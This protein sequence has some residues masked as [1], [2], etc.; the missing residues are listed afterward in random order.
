MRVDSEEFARTFGN[1][2]AAADGSDVPVKRSAGGP[3]SFMGD[4]GE[5]GAAAAPAWSICLASVNFGGNTP[6]ARWILLT[7]RLSGLPSE[8]VSAKYSPWTS[9]TSLSTEF[10]VGFVP[11]SF[12]DPLVTPRAKEFSQRSR[13]CQVAQ[14]STRTRKTR[15]MAAISRDRTQSCARAPQGGWTV[16]GSD[17]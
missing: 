7:Q 16:Q 1:G 15:L 3:G 9:E 8:K 12:L 14:G 10:M 5:E 17:V 4:V 2:V 11:Q 13:T 6:S